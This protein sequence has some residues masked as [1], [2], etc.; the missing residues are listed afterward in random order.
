MGSH[1]HVACM[2][3]I[4]LTLDCAMVW[5]MLCRCMRAEYWCRFKRNDIKKSSCCKQLPYPQVS[6]I[7]NR[8]KAKHVSE[9]KVRAG[10]ADARV[11]S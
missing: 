7:H 4:M 11:P 5:D 10:H 1:T 9:D 8:I 2:G 3:A 6:V